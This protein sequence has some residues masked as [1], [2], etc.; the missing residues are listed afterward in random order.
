MLG[1]SGIGSDVTIGGD[2]GISLVD[3]AD[4][5]MSLEQPLDLGG[6]SAESLELGEDDMLRPGRAAKVRP[7]H[8]AA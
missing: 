8:P 7:P 2:S 4:S 3:P 6:A 5:G 1:G